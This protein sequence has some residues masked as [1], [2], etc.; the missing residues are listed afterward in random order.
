M[1]HI[2]V[3]NQFA[4]AFYSDS[5]ILGSSLSST[6]PFESTNHVNRHCEIWHN[7]FAEGTLYL[8][9]INT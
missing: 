2:M 7:L 8:V 6:K 4:T 9:H 3:H 1:R 5:L